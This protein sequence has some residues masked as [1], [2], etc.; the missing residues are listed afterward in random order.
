MDYLLDQPHWEVA[1][2]QD[3]DAFFLALADLCP[4][5]ATLCIAECSWPP[6]VREALSKVAVTADPSARLVSEFDQACR[7]P[8]TLETMDFLSDLA[9]RHAELDIGIHFAVYVEGEPCLEWFDAIADPICLSSSFHEFQVQ[10]FA[11]DLRAQYQRLL[12]G[13]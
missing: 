2:V 11:D 13:V 3:L 1:G 12:G 8:I 7:V 10:R 5:R 6:A 4:D 9:K